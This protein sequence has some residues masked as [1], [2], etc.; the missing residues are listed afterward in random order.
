MHWLII[1]SVIARNF[2]WIILLRLS[3]AFGLLLDIS[4]VTRE[5]LPRKWFWWESEHLASCTHH[6][7]NSLQWF[8][9][10]MKLIH[11]YLLNQSKLLS[12][13]SPRNPHMHVCGNDILCTRFIK[14]ILK[15]WMSAS[16]KTSHTFNSCDGKS[17]WIGT[18]LIH[19]K[20]LGSIGKSLSTKIDFSPRHFHSCDCSVV[21]L[22]Q[23]FSFL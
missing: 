7:V 22:H 17:I 6:S 12:K 3:K 11:L 10:F 18:F 15:A 16:E 9:I 14:S 21:G 8:S 19:Y 20:H 23:S 5:S 1:E 4:T 13:I 2:C